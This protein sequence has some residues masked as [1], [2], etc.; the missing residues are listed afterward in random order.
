MA[1]LS[2][3]LRLQ[4]H[5]VIAFTGAG[6]KTSAM[7]LS[8]HESNPAIASTSTHIGDWQASRAERHFTW[9]EDEPMPDMEIYTGNGVT[10]VTGGHILE[11]HRYGGLNNSQLEKLKQ[12]A[13]YHD[14]PLLIEADGSRQTALKAPAEHEPVIPPFTDLVVVTAG[15]SSLNKPL[16]EKFAFRPEIFSELSGLK[17]GE[18]ITPAALAMVL[19]HSRGGL[20]NIPAFARR[21]LIL[22]QADTPMLQSFAGQMAESLL[23]DYHSV[24]VTSLANQP[25][26]VSAVYEK[27]AALIFSTAQPGHN[28]EDNRFVGGI[29]RKAIL[30]GL[31]PVIVVASSLNEEI[32][33]AIAGLPVQFIIPPGGQEG[34]G[35]FIRAGIASLPPFCGGTFM[36]RL[37]QPQISVQLLRAMMQHHRQYLPAVLAPY[38]F[39]QRST[40]YLL[41]RVTFAD[42]LALQAHAGVR[43]VFSKFSP[44]YLNWY[45]RRLLIPVD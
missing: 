26:P 5:H 16:N 8:A 36:L 30:A 14:L 24:L 21:A 34:E 12:F 19:K 4:Q 35:A 25:E 15:L 10:L 42:L 33:N 18:I 29:A 23:A 9:M 40:P 3:S 31:D 20:K 6:G 11:K 39:D 7:F 37:N 38:V 13:G 22:N 32:Q 41:D 1:N 17:M 43:E 44:R 45:D 27:T 2:R 28:L